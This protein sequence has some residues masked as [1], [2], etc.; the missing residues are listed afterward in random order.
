M[1]LFTLNLAG[2]RGLE[3]DKKTSPVQEEWSKILPLEHIS[4]PR[5]TYPMARKQATQHPSSEAEKPTRSETETWADGTG[6]AT[7]VFSSPAYQF[8]DDLDWESEMFMIQGL[9]YPTFLA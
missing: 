3:S 8:G 1:Q 4:N 5:G 6:G 7:D 2:L 9:G